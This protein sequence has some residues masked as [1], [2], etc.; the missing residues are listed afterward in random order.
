MAENS[1]DLQSAHWRPKKVNGVVLAQR[2]GN[3]GP[4][5]ELMFP[6]ES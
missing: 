2:P 4:Q 1:Q 6:L 3:T 5:K